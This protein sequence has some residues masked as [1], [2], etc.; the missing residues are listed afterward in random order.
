MNRC[1]PPRHAELIDGNLVVPRRRRKW[2]VSAV[3]RLKA[4]LDRQAPAG[5]RADREM[6]VRL[7]RRQAPEPD[8]MVVTAEAFERPEP[9]TYYFVEDVVL[10]V[11][12]VSPDSE[13]R[14]RD[15]KPRKYAAAGIPHFWRVERQDGRT[16]VYVYERD[17]ATGGYTPTGI[18]HERLKVAVPFPID[19]DLAFV[20]R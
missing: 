20:G 5:L 4:E 14:D 3:D 17:P 8:I 9:D 6:T 7:A 19:V 15:T 11:E 12:V 1:D 16:V 10:A 18:Y 13:E 2:H